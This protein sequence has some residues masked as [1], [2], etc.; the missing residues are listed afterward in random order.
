[1]R[2]YTTPTLTFEI[3]ADL[4]GC[5][6]WITLRQGRRELTVIEFDAVEVSGGK[7]YVTLTLTQRQ[8]AAFVMGRP[9]DVQANI[10]DS[11]GHR[12]ASE[13]RQINVDRQLMEREVGSE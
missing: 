9:V 11:T 4:T 13:V 12:V 3:G 10:I 2:R 1:M 7:T 5:D 6:V 8:T